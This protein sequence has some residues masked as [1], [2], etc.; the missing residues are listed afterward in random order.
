MKHATEFPAS[1]TPKRR[2]IGTGPVL[3]PGTL[4]LAPLGWDASGS[5][6]IRSTAV[7]M[8][9]SGDVPSLNEG[10]NS[11]RFDGSGALRL[12]PVLLL[13]ER[14]SMFRR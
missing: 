14:G 2:M 6:V 7:H 4:K 11:G 12:Q 3:D 13:S 9:A 10:S 1:L 5:P 8:K